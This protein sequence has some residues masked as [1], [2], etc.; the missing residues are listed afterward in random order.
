VIEIILSPCRPALFP[1]KWV[2]LFEARRADRLLCTSRQP[3]VDAARVLASEG[4][5]PHTVIRARR[6]GSDTV[7]LTAKLSV[8]AR[9][10][11]DESGPHLRRWKAMPAREGSRFI[12]ASVPEAIPGHIERVPL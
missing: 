11:V 2:G 9:L 3:F 4:H 6:A 5:D 12:D 8:A 1:K 7:A 10:T